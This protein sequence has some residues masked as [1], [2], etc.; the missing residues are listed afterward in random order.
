MQTS[1]C[2]L[3]IERLLAYL[4]DP[5]LHRAEAD[6][7]I[8]HMSTCPYCRGRMDR[9]IRA[10]ATGEEDRLTCR[11]CQDLLPGYLQAEMEGQ[12]DEERRHSVALHLATCPHCSTVYASLRD[13][14][15]LAY[16]EKGGEPLHYPVPDLSFLRPEKAAP[17][18]MPKI[19]WRL[20]EWGRLVIE[21]SSELLRALQAPACQPAYAAAGL[22]SAG[23]RR[24]LYRFSLKEVEDLEVTITAEEMRKDPARCTLIVEV[25]IPDRGGWPN[26]AGTEVRLRRGEQELGTQWTD[27]F[28]QAVFEGVHTEDL[29]HLVFEIAPVQGP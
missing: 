10:L 14:A 21:F 13:L 6:A 22:K 25:D 1:E 8:K 11:E 23:S 3:A 7:A 9:F 18:P 29:A 16:G 28:G 2:R 19:P 27:A 12:A 17:L 20:D 15:E 4:E 5:D 24:V 26:L